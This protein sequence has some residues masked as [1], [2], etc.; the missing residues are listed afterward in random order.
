MLA[1][2]ERAAALESLNARSVPGKDGIL[3]GAPQNG[4]T[5]KKKKM[6]DKLNVVWT[7]CLILENWRYTSARYSEACEAY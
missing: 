6:R 2:A 5:T 4:Q 1:V 3:G 7:S